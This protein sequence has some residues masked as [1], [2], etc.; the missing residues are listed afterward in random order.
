MKSTARLTIGEVA[1]RAGLRPSAIRYFEDQGLLPAA[2]RRAGRRVYDETVLNRL[3]VIE[4][5]KA[6]GLT[7]REIRELLADAGGRQP[8][9][10]RWRKL[11]E[12][13]M[14]EL[15]DRIAQTVQMKTVLSALATCTC[16]TLDDCGR[17]FELLRSAARK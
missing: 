13:K 14:I 9:G 12:P 5:A 15:D 17:A 2:D 4:L 1:A 8:A 10:F 16:S 11:A 7:I 3:A 6:A